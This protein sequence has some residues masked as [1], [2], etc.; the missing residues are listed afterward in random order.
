MILTTARGQAIR[1]KESQLRP[2]GRT[3]GGVTAIRL[4]KGDEMSSMDIVVSKAQ[5]APQ[6]SA[7]G[8]A[9]GKSP[10]LLVIMANGYG[11]QTAL[12]EYKVQRRGGVGILTA[13][14]TAKTGALVAAHLVTDEEELIALS[15]KGQVIRAP[16]SEVRTANRA[17]QGVRIMS[18]HEGDKVA[19]VVCL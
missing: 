2:L 12:K 10:R 14:I 8:Q 1:F 15:A 6:S 17:T 4:K 9:D 3:A 18:L 11:K 16:L 5:S 13:K 19:G 7:A